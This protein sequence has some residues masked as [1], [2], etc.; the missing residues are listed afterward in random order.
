MTRGQMHECDIIKSRLWYRHEYPC[1]S[2][3]TFRMDVG[4]A[5]R[6]VQQR[7]RL[8]TH[9][10]YVDQALSTLRSLRHSVEAIKWGSYVE[11]TPTEA[12]NR[13]QCD[14]GG[15]SECVA[16]LRLPSMRNRAPVTRSNRVDPTNLSRGL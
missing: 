4:S 10:R 1:H 8:E 7:K 16:R 3:D 12:E 6:G 11:F 9:S 5:F 15:G 2:S 13:R 14:F